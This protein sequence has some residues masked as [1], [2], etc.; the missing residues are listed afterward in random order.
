MGNAGS[1]KT[2][3]LDLLSVLELCLRC[4]MVGDFRPQTHIGL[5]DLFLPTRKNKACCRGFTKPR[6]ESK[7]CKA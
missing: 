3:G 1:Y 7:A 6:P 4:T 5:V 2:D